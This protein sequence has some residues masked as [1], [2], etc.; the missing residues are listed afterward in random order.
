LDIANPAREIAPGLKFFLFYL[1]NLYT[2]D[3]FSAYIIMNIGG[4]RR[5]TLQ[6]R[7]GGGVMEII[8]VLCRRKFPRC[9]S[10]LVKGKV[11]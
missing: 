3:I 1:I 5:V 8:A 10:L 6:Y 2:I 7:K 11:G 4:G 9:C